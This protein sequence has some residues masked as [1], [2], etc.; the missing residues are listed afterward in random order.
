MKRLKQ[1]LYFFSITF[2]VSTAAT[3]GWTLDSLQAQNDQNQPAKLPIFRLSAA[4]INEK[5]LHQLARELFEVSGKLDRR[6]E[7]L[8]IKS[9]SK[10]VEIF[11][12]SGGI[13]AADEARMWNPELK[14]ELP[15]E[16]QARSL[17]EA[18]LA[19]HRLLPVPTDNQ[20]FQ[21]SFSNVGGTHAAFFDAKQ[22]Q[23]TER[24]LD[25]QVNYS[26]KIGLSNF[27]MPGRSLPVVGGGGE[28]NL[29]LGD[30][31]DVIGYQ[32]VWRQI[33][34]V[35]KESPI[36]PQ[37]NAD[38]QFRYLVRGM[39][40]HSVESYLA[41]YSAPPS[42]RQEFL[43]PVY[44]YRAVAQIDDQTV[45]LR[46]ITLPAT[47]F[48]PVRPEGK[49]LPARTEKDLPSRRST[50][51]EDSKERESGMKDKS[52]IQTP[53]ITWNSFL[54]SGSYMFMPPAL[55]REA[56]TSWIG[57]S[58]GL[59]GSQN[60]AQG[61]VDELSADGWNINFNWGD[62]NAWESDWH[63]RNKDWVDA[64]DFVFYTG[65]AN[66]NG[67]VLRNPD[68]GF[69]DFSEVGAGPES[70]GDMWGR[71]DLEW[72]IIAACGPLQDDVISPGGGDVFARWD[73]AFDG[74][75][76]LLGY[77]AI[78]FDNQEEGR[79]VA[80]YAKEG[81]TLINAWFRA[82]REIQPSDNGA[83]APDGPRIWVGVMYVG[84]S[85]VTDPGNDHIWLHGSVASDPT[86]PNFYVAM[87]TTT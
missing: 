12:Q 46:L 51:P 38:E 58:G 27:G 30:K 53:S 78:T 11:V 41:Y 22:K 3:S 5:D 52:E 80:R 9:G 87:W 72:V 4:R 1:V 21:V 55:W 71:E 83:S 76:E 18:Y 39:K 31:G 68:D 47:E 50:V 23:R 77:G 86:S 24:Q 61:F 84:R 13:W 34:G 59:G 40:I 32:G 25:I 20:P 45:P 64:A 14:P 75:H 19:K 74:L 54:P 60:N 26:T 8:S 37:K 82:A 62:A 85:G 10:L 29:T 57:L 2:L 49:S 16:K 63:R 6:E 70:P 56:G 42:V 7:R 48:G 81:E 17:A 15:D 73:G 43:Y 44:V 66:M 36:V 35:E 28:F 65:H 69:L 79:S 33:A 67:W